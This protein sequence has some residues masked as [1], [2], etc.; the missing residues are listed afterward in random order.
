[1]V[2]TP[3][4]VTNCAEHLARG[5]VD[6]LEKFSWLVSFAFSNSSAQMC[7]IIIAYHYMAIHFVY[8]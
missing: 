6:S 4:S 2:W 7:P 8:L 1:M 5:N 3:L